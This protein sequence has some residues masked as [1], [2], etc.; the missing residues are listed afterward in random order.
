MSFTVFKK[1]SFSQQQPAIWWEKTGDS[2]GK[3]LNQPPNY[4]LAGSKKLIT[5]VLYHIILKIRLKSQ[6]KVMKVKEYREADN[7]ESYSAY[8]L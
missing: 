8:F 6:I 1:I 2:Q 5:L 7:D 3:T 4:K